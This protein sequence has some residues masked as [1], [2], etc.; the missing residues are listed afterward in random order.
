MGQL[1][2]KKSFGII[3]F[4]D[5]SN[6]KSVKRYCPICGNVLHKWILDPEQNYKAITAPN[7]LQCLECGEIIQIFHPS[8][9]S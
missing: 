7:K 3:D 4:P 1:K 5:P 9:L 6:M 8:S 2:R